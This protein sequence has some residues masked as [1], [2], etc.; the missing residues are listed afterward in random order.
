VAFVADW[1]GDAALNPRLL[2]SGL[3]RRFDDIDADRIGTPD[4]AWLADVFPAAQGA[5]PA[6]RF[7]ARLLAVAAGDAPRV[8]QAMWDSSFQTGR[9]AMD[10]ATAASP[11]PST[12][13]S[14]AAPA[15]SPSSRPN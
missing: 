8:H 14:T 10:A 5:S 7:A 1:V 2:P 15:S 3:L 4:P 11:A 12:T 6:E 13:W 9:R